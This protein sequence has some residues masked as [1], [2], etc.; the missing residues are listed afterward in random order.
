MISK[1]TFITNLKLVKVTP[2]VG[3]AIVECGTWRGGMIAA[4]GQLLGT[5]RRYWLFDSFEGL[6]AAEEVDGKEAK[7]WQSNVDSPKYFD[8]CRASESEAVA[9]MKLAGIYDARITKGWFEETLPRA[10]FEDG[11]A[12]L[13]MDGDWYKSTWEILTQLFPK[14]NKG[15]L[16]IIDDY[17][18]WE[19]CSK[20]VHDYLSSNNRS[21]KIQSYRGLCYLIKES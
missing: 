20:A 18:L 11:I 21:E 3:G 2:L 12:L 6:P 1:D 9:A 16:I 19:G 10:S 4:I 13:R 14:V 7:Q 17:F 15:G 5:G 8:N